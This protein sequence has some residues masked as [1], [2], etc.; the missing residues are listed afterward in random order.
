MYVFKFLGK[1]RYYYYNL[2]ILIAINGHNSPKN[3]HINHAT[4]PK[5]IYTIIIQWLYIVIYLG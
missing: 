5:I 1:D 3:F 4:I 2:S